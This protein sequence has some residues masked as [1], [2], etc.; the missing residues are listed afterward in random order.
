MN[1]KESS[2]NLGLDEEEY[3]ELIELFIETGMSD[4]EKL[5]SAINEGNTENAANA[6]HSLKGAASNLGFMELSE[7]AKG[8]EEKT[9]NGQMEGAAEAALVIKEKMDI[10]ADLV[11]K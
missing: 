4:L 3:L 5:H 9:R 1:F 6:A 8:I 7:T 2:E 11:E 10:I